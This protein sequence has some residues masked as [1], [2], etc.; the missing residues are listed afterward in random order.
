MRGEVAEAGRAFQEAEALEREVHSLPYLCS[1]RGIQHADY[2]RLSDD[3]NYAR[4]V[5]VANFLICEAENWCDMIN[6]CH[7][8]MGDL[9]ASVGQQAEAAEHYL[10]AL[11]LARSSSNR[12]VL[13]EALLARGRWE[14]RYSQDS[15]SAFCDL[16]EALGYALAGGYRIYEADIRV[17]LAWAYLVANNKEA[18]REEAA[19]ALRMSE[20][21]DYYWGKVDADEILAKIAME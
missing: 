21:M 19:Y 11:N 16:K 10:Q 12:L 17:A 1:L 3:A 7:R 4:K 2:L 5:T 8:V 15:E 18:A 14:A 20:A 6:R 9:Y 13:T